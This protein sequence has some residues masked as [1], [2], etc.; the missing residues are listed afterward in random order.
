MKI[1]FYLLRHTLHTP[2]KR[3]HYP[4]FFSL[5]LMAWV[6]EILGYALLVHPLIGLFLISL[7][8][9]ILPASLLTF[10]SH[11][12]S[13]FLLQRYYDLSYEIYNKVLSSL[14]QDLK[15]QDMVKSNYE[16]LIEKLK[17][18][19]YREILNSETN[20]DEIIKCFYQ[21][22]FKNE[23]RK[24]L[25]LF[26]SSKAS[27]NPLSPSFHNM[28]ALM[29]SWHTNNTELSME[30]TRILSNLATGTFLLENNEK[31]PIFFKACLNL[32]ISYQNF[33]QLGI[34]IFK[35]KEKTFS[36]SSSS[37]SLARHMPWLDRTL[38]RQDHT[39]NSF[40]FA[41]DF[42]YSAKNLEES[43]S[44]LFGKKP[45]LKAW[46]L[47]HLQNKKFENHRLY[48]LN[49]SILASLWNLNY[50]HL[51]KEFQSS[52]W[53]A[54]L[55]IE[56]RVEEIEL[57]LFGQLLKRNYT[58]EKII[59][60]LSS[61][62]RG[63]FT[64]TLKMSLSFMAQNIQA[65]LPKKI[66]SFNELHDFFTLHV[67]HAPKFNEKLDQEEI[68]ELH[69]LTFENFIISIPKNRKDLF[70]LGQSLKICVGASDVYAGDV[71]RG[72][73][74]LL[75]LKEDGEYRYCVQVDR[76]TLKIIQASTFSNQKMDYTLKF[77]LE[78]FLA[79]KLG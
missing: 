11:F 72:L 9:T 78:K 17:I 3:F 5:E 22:K 41:K 7:R 6:I 71:Q 53:E 38:F 51:L 52:N 74:Y 58:D 30:E 2:V 33:P 73:C 67:K 45:K 75:A 48:F 39:Y 43:F 18:A 34:N 59:K 21:N 12:F 49:Y 24:G 79:E 76:T 20:P 54:P 15:N 27:L 68:K 35:M 47:E 19:I 10:I 77:T 14:I 70:S 37:Y 66:K 28:V 42:L 62:P 4:G 23:F 16:G 55:L 32:K 13:F 8:V 46:W 44:L 31:L 63:V 69:G 64:D 29:T 61:S 57:L 65:P 50:D 40:M 36:F 26:L 56:S 1:G 25:F 60:L